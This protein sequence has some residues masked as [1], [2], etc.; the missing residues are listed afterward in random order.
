MK[1]VVTGGSGFLGKH[2]IA[3]LLED[4]HKVTALG[5]EEI[6]DSRLRWLKHDLV[7]QPFEALQNEVKEAEGM[8]HLAAIMPSKMKDRTTGITD[9]AIIQKNKLM[10]EHALSLANSSKSLKQFIFASSVDVYPYSD[11]IVDESIPL[12]PV[13]AYGQSKK[14][15]EDLCWQWGKKNPDVSLT[16]LRFSHMYGPAD[17]NHKMIDMLVRNALLGKKSIIYGEGNDKRTYLFVEDAVKAILLCLQK[18]DEAKGIFNVGGAQSYSVKEIISAVEEMFK[19][20]VDIEKRIAGKK[21]GS[22]IVSSAKV[23][24][25]IGFIPKTDLRSGLL[26]LVPKNIFFDLDGPILDVKKRYYAVYRYFVVKNNGKP[27]ALD[28]YWEQKRMNVSLEKLLQMSGCGGLV[29]EHKKYLSLHREEYA[30]LQLDELQP[31]VRELLSHL[32]KR[33]NLYLITL[34]RNTE[35]LL[36]QLKELNILS[37]FAKVLSVAPTSESKWQH[38]VDLLSEDGL[39]L[40]AGIII[41][42]TP[43]EILAARK[44]GFTSVGVAN[45]IRTK[46]IL[47]KAEPHLVVESVKQLE[48]LPFYREF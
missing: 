6:K 44:V 33:H 28:E 29:V 15:S 22:S 43:T 1:I 36:R 9:T 2:L 46:D 27:L 31:R 42:D 30:F 8:I 12:N 39:Q 16:M 35:N 32:S 3:A 20:E 14:E 26:K 23:E 47:I 10:M 40:K 18:K 37:F 48:S 4:G 24:K 21:S 7:E 25:T 13:S 5:R 38:K 11:G 34:R 19:L 45:G 41:G 17:T